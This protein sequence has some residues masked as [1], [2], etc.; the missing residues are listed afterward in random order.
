MNPDE[1]KAH[2]WAI[3][4]ALIDG[5]QCQLYLLD[6]WVDQQPQ[7]ILEKIKEMTLRG[8]TAVE[9]SKTLKMPRSSVY[10]HMPDR[11]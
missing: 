9:I 2:R 8:C 11:V 5:K 10:R 6:G 1:L 3:C 7:T 4:E